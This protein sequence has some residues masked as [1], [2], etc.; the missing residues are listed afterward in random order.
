MSETCPACL[1]ENAPVWASKGGYDICRCTVCGFGFVE[2]MP[3]VEVLAALYAEKSYGEHEDATLTPGELIERERLFPNAVLDARRMIRRAMKMMEASGGAKHLLDVGSGFGFA[4]RVAQDAGLE[5]TALEVSSSGREATKA[6]AGIET[7]GVRFE[8]FESERS[9]DIILMSQVIEHVR[10]INL[11]AEKAHSLLAEG[12]VLVMAMPNL[13]SIVCKVLGSHDPYVT[14]PMHLGYFTPKACRR[15]LERH[16][17]SDICVSGVSRLGP[18]TTYRRIPWLPEQ[19]GVIRVVRALQDAP[20][21]LF[22]LMGF[23]IM[24]NVYA[25]KGPA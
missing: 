12:G 16:S 8:E 4:S 19:P 10:D 5:V 11:W 20:C 13:D 21:R 23:P 2:P 17:F 9:F 1:K 3:S 7:E 14:P 18:R 6:I 25:R 15:W 24:L 22:G